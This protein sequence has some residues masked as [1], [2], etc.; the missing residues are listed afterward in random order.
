MIKIFTNIIFTNIIFKRLLW[1]MKE[2]YDI[3]CKTNDNL[4]GK[5]NYEMLNNYSG[6]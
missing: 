5:E 3:I 1:W 4:V 2:Q 6:I